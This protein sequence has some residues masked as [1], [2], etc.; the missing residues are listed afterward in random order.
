MKN[1]RKVIY[2][3]LL[4]ALEILMTRFIQIPLSWAPIF[5]LSKDRI[6]L[7]FLPIAVAGMLMGPV[8]GGLVGAIADIIRAIIFPVG[9]AFNPLFT[10]SAGLKGV[11][12][13]SIL[14]KNCSFTRIIIASLIIGIFITLFRAKTLFGGAAQTT[15]SGAYGRAHTRVS[16]KGTNHRT[17]CTTDQTT[18]TRPYHRFFC[19]AA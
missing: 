17:T 7:G 5:A 8:Y 2:A 3:G 11:I 12:Y 6:S 18:Y 16:G 13:G 19:G 4:I 14:K 15:R 1:T 9:G 10:I